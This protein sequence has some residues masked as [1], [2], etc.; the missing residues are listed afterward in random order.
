[1]LRIANIFDQDLMALARQE[2][3]TIMDADPLLMDPRH[4]A[5]AAERERFLTRVQQ[6]IGD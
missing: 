3:L 5:I 2:A 4:A 6:H 1:M